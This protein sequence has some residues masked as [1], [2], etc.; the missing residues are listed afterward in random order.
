MS[1]KLSRFTY[2]ARHLLML[3]QE[4]AI[5]LN[6]KAIDTEHLLLGML[7][8]TQALST[9]ALEQLGIDLTE[10][11]REIENTVGR[12]Q[13]TPFGN[14]SLAPHA[15]RVIELSVETARIMGHTY[16]GTEHLLLG[17]VEAEDGVAGKMLR[18][19]TTPDEYLD[20][21][22][23]ILTA[24]HSKQ[25][26]PVPT[27]Q[28]MKDA[29][30]R[31]DELS[32]W[33]EIASKRN[34][35]VPPELAT[36]EVQSL[37][38]KSP[39]WK[40]VASLLEAIQESS[41]VAYLTGT[42]ELFTGTSLLSRLP[43]AIRDKIRKNVTESV[44]QGE[45]A[46]LAR[47]LHDSIK[48][49]LFSISTSAAAIEA[50]WESDPAGAKT[51]L[52]DVQYSARAAMVEM[53]AMLQQLSPTPLSATGLTEAIRQQCEALDYRT[54]AEVTTVIGELPSAERLPLGT[55]EAI[56][57][58]IQE[59]LSN[60]ARHARAQKVHLRLEQQTQPDN[61]QP[62]LALEIQ[63]DGQGFDVEHQSNGMGLA[64]MAVRAEELSGTMVVSSAV[65]EGTTLRVEIPLLSE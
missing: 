52:K 17:L 20:T 47:D 41:V 64:N 27:A 50:R 40:E 38:E 23:K 16:V 46:R 63:D 36:K 25:N 26:T 1:D 62:I 57:R 59:A 58:I 14:P 61:E 4:E 60:I 22:V 44:A 24:I 21:I 55:Q 49:Q 29:Q 19:H 10:M 34:T 9:K 65:G 43:G 2:R 8:D 3:A 32:K 15:K 11:L 39:K 42:P 48:Q 35:P 51:A 53:D 54:G 7:R 5:R 30:P 31:I 33:K 37:L 18:Q 45:R 56:F 28:M 12:G 6:H 13:R